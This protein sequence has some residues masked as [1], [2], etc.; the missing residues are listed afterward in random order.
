MFTSKRYFIAKKLKLISESFDKKSKELDK[1]GNMKTQ[2]RKIYNVQSTLE[3]MRTCIMTL[4]VLLSFI[5]QPKMSCTAKECL[6]CYCPSF[7][8]SKTSKINLLLIPFQKDHTT[9]ARLA[10]KVVLIWHVFTHFLRGSLDS[11]SPIICIQNL[12]EGLRSCL[13]W[14][15]ACT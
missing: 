9:I 5:A 6:R 4:N 11:T 2:W 3:T 13:T 8:W 7:I 1:N 10:I 15:A 14:N 12:T